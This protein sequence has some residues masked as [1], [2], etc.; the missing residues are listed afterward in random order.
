MAK[1]SIVEISRDLA[2]QGASTL[3]ICDTR[4]CSQSQLDLSRRK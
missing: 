4:I 1:P 2:D 3:P